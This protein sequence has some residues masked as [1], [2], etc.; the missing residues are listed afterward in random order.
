[1]ETAWKS[2]NVKTEMEAP[3]PSLV[4][5]ALVQTESVSRENEACQTEKSAGIECEVQANL[6]LERRTFG[7]QT[8]N[9][10]NDETA[11]TI[12]ETA[13]TNDETDIKN[14]EVAMKNI[15]SK[16][17]LEKNLTKFPPQKIFQIQTPN[18]RHRVKGK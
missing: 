18:L 12:N 4:I 1:M 17:L 14:D 11:L 7:T 5:D 13:I 6:Y 9:V 10:D 15:P 8:I 3:V 2:N 16:I